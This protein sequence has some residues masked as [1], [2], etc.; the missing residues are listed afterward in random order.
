MNFG[1]L[2]R[3]EMHQRMQRLFYQQVKLRQQ[4]F[5]DYKC[6]TINSEYYT[7]LFD[8]LDEKFSEH[9]PGLAKKKSFYIKIMQLLITTF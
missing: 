8:Q 1:F 4:L 9:R 2:K 3:A 7:N 5:W 6:K